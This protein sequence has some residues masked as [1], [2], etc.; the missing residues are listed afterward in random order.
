MQIPGK[1]RRSRRRSRTYT[2]D[3]KVVCRLSESPE[4][5]NFSH[6]V[7]TRQLAVSHDGKHA[8]CTI[9]DRSRFALQH[10]HAT[11]SHFFA[12]DIR[13][14]SV[15]PQSVRVWC[16][17]VKGVAGVWEVN[18]NTSRLINRLDH[19]TEYFETSQGAVPSGYNDNDSTGVRMLIM[20]HGPLELSN[21][22]E[23][24]VFFDGSVF[25]Y[26]SV[27]NYAYRYLV[28]SSGEIKDWTYVPEISGAISHLVFLLGEHMFVRQSDLGS[29]LLHLKQS[30][31]STFSRGSSDHNWFNTPLDGYVEEAWNSPTGDAFAL[32]VQTD[33]PSDER[34][35]HRILMHNGKRLYR[36]RFSMGVDD[37]TWSSN[38]QHCA[39][40]LQVTSLGETYDV[41]KRGII[42]SSGSK[43]MFQLPEGFSASE[44]LLDDEG[45][46]KAFVL[47][48]GKR[49][50]PYVNNKPHD[51]VSIAWNL[52]LTPEGWVQ[53]NRIVSNR[54]VRIIDRT[55]AL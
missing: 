19:I 23:I 54:V 32:L 29:A 33:L 42:I 37:V 52:Q 51:L 49:F 43:Q 55:P 3:E 28:D 38:G 44:V 47:T 15:L 36:G 53:Y 13:I 46:I 39:A 9:Q 17:P 40:Y 16:R 24:V 10:S 26:E 7:N 45:V 5:R 20:P 25:V 50:R 22:A 30:P 6:L 2:G 18:K 14:L 34:G 31:T 35:I 27:E 41:E 11:L 48:D 12:R 4:E 1:G 8:A 21:E